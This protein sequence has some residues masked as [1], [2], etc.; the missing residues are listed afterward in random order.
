MTFPVR[1]GL[2]VLV[3]VLSQVALAPA[4][5]P[6]RVPDRLERFREVVAARLAPAQ[7]VGF[8]AEDAYREVY[9]LLDEEIVE[10]LATG[11]VFA[12]PAFLQDRLDAFSEAWGGASIRLVALGRVVL[13][14]FQFGDE[15][16]SSVRAYGGAGPAAALLGVLAR[17]GRPTVHL[18]PP[19]PGRVAQALA[20]WEGPATGH[21]A[22]PVRFDLLREHGAAGF[23]MPWSSAELFPEG[24]PSRAH[25]VRGAELRVRY[26]LRYP[27]WA[28]GCEGQTEVEDVYRLSPGTGT[29]TLAGRREHH[30]WHRDVHRSAARLFSALSEGDRA[31]LASLVPDPKLR[32]KL[33]AGL[34][35][36]PA[37]DSVEG[38]GGE[39]VSIAAAT[40]SQHPWT[41][42][43]RRTGTAWRLT[44]AAPAIP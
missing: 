2:P 29:F 27:G 16:S 25:S 17:S 19:G 3:A 36:A 38:L 10:S 4:A 28:P 35:G 14:V 22:R 6:A 37:C 23:H 32:E 20:V 21:G 31:A 43:F 11:G 8:A 12:S 42:T 15:G 18:L 5:W 1:R 26:E 7:L 44:A 34:R 39:A 40:E 41:L 13:G 33:P 9:A 24:L 30:G